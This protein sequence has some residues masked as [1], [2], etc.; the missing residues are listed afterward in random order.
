MQ[1]VILAAGKGKRL[2]PVTDGRSKAMVPVLGRPLV[3]RAIEPLV[4]NGIREFVFVV[5]PNDREIFAHFKE[6]TRLGVTARFV[7]QEQQLGTAHALGTAARL[8][9]GPFAVWACD[10]LVDSDHVAALLA[11]AEKADASLSLL[12]VEPELVSRSAAVELDGNDVRRIVEKPAP[13]ESPSHTVSLPHY[14]FSPK[15]LDL[16]PAVR[17]SSRGEYELAD[18][19]QELIQR[20]ARVL[21]VR[22]SSR[23]QVS[24]PEDLLVLTRKLL[25]AGK[26]FGQTHSRTNRIE[27]LYV[28]P[29]VTIPGDTEI[30][31][32]VYLEA[33][34]Q[35][36]AGAVIRRSIV[37]RGG[38][39]ADG[40]K[41]E[42]AVVT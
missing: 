17:L 35:V 36:G 22:A 18:A 27:P 37:L 34:C 33:G 39:V 2:R 20:G 32:E 31:P 11:S 3:E 40:E 16:L 29:G 5:S 38:V 30:G 4:E 21:G 26:H 14:L 42:D 23:V 25:E 41:I 8:I 12:D 1:A 9:G 10:S 13:D 7:V 24:S 19:I 6:S 15:V 28:E